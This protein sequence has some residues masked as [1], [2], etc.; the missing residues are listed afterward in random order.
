MLIQIEKPRRGSGIA[1][2]EERFAAFLLRFGPK[3][4]DG[5]RM[6]RALAGAPREERRFNIRPDRCRKPRVV[7]NE[8]VRFAVRRVE[9]LPAD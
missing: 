7:G 2:V 1:L 4:K 3:R 6:P 9:S 8:L 5:A